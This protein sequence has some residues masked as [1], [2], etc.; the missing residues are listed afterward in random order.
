MHPKKV[1]VVV[2]LIMAKVARLGFL[3]I[4]EILA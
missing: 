1:N 4:N 2:R 3:N